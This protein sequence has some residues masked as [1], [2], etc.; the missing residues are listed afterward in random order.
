MTIF[1]VENEISENDGQCEVRQESAF[2]FRDNTSIYTD[3]QHRFV[4]VKR[5]CIAK[6]F[7]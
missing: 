7:I 2:G 1:G 3:I 6:I 5:K 4:I